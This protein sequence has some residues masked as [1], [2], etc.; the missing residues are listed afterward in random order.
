M[1]DKQM[2][3]AMPLGTIFATGTAK[4]NPG[5]LFMH[6]TDELIRWVAVRGYGPGDWAI[7]CLEA[8]CDPGHI[9]KMGDK[10]W[11]ES[12]IRKLVPCDDGAFNLYR[13]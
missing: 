6:G 11:D 7:Y 5:E 8:G 10:V 13:Y 2:L 12:H 1:L 4:D 9:A 3:D